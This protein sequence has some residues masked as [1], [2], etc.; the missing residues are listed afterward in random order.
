MEAA[1]K[2][3]RCEAYFKVKSDVAYTVV[4]YAYGTRHHPY[5]QV[6]EP[7]YLC[8]D[9]MKSF[10]KWLNAECNGSNRSDDEWK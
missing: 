10:W 5:L 9:C 3:D 2:C 7:L 1:V 4:V 6:G 8:P